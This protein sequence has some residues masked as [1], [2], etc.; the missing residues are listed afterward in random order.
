MTTKPPTPGVVSLDAMAKQR[1]D[2]L[3]APTPFE[4]MGVQ[5]TLPPMKALPIEM[6]ERVSSMNDGFAV[7]KDILGPAKVKEMFAAGY[8]FGDLEL[9]S[10]EWQARSGLEPG[11]SPAS[12]SS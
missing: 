6:Q 10:E 2:A 11:E 8:T 12:P 3:P 5:F 7:L 9:I 1:R 4:L